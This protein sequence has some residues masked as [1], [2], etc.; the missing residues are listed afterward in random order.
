MRPTAAK[1]VNVYKVLTTCTC[2]VLHRPC[3]RVPP[4][5]ADR[6]GTHG[7]RLAMSV[8]AKVDDRADAKV[9]REHRPAEQG[10]HGGC[11]V[12]VGGALAVHVGG[13]LAPTDTGNNVPSFAHH[14]S[15]Q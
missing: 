9:R 12:G 6:S 7:E 4:Q 14:R 11:A 13:L 2:T 5:V 3:C 15:E 10:L 1:Q 8:D